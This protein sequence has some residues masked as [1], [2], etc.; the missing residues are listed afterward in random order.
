MN[1]NSTVTIYFLTIF[2]VLKIS[3]FRKTIA[4]VRFHDKHRKKKKDQSFHIYKYNFFLEPKKITIHINNK[5]ISQK[6]SHL[7]TRAKSVV[8]VR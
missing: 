8:F 6:I 1:T 3:I 7:D 4:T 2:N 5:K